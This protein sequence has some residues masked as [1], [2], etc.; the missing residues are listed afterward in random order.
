MTRKYTPVTGDELVGYVELII[1]IYPVHPKF[2]NGGVF[3][4]YLDSLQLG[5]SVEIRGPI[6]R[7][8]YE[9][10]GVFACRRLGTQIFDRKQFSSLFI[11]AGGTGIT[12]MLQVVYS[13]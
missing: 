8:I 7:I 12:P 2:T 5:D 13:K 10:N 11:L 6:T 3:S 1:K 4:L 9:G